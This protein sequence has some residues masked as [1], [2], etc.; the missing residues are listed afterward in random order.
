MHIVLSTYLSKPSVI[1]VLP[2]FS[3]SPSY[4]LDLFR[5]CSLR[6]AQAQVIGL[7][8]LNWPVA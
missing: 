1:S 7:S 2:L 4:L 6:P 8:V 3:F 5:A